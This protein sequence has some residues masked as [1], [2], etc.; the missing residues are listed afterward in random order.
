[1]G[2]IMVCQIMEL[3]VECYAG[4]KGNERPRLFFMDDRRFEVRVLLDTWYGPDDEYFR[5]LAD[6][7]NLYVLRHRHADPEDVWTLEAYRKADG[8][9]PD[10]D[11]GA[12]A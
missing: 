1:M 4:Y 10:F 3:R 7:G 8:S 9:C 11:P 5:V 2:V 12:S 6:D